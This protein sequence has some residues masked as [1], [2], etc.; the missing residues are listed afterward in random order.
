MQGSIDSEAVQATVQFN[1][2]LAKSRAKRGPFYFDSN[3]RTVQVLSSPIL[4]HVAEPNKRVVEVPLTLCLE[5]FEL[6][7]LFFLFF[8]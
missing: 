7:F 1:Q 4:P 8:F 2:R 5:S 3:T 6:F